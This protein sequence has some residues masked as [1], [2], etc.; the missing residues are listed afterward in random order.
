MSSL[1]NHWL[2]RLAESEKP[3]YLM[4]PDMI[5]EDLASGRLRARDRLPALRD[6]ADALRLNYTTVARGYAEA[7]KRG[8][9]DAKAGSGT[10]VRGR[11][12]ALPLQAGTGAEMSMNMPPEP[13]SMTV[14]LREAAARILGDADPYTLL[15][16]QDFGGTPADRSIAT[17]W[18]RQQLPDCRP[19]TVL[20]CPGIHSA[21]VALV[22]QLARP[23][24]TICLDTLAYPGIKAIAAQLGV[25]L[26][27]LPS[28]EEGPLGPAF[29]ALCRT[30][31]PSAFYINPTLQNPSTRTMPQGRREILADIALRYNVPIIED[32]AYGMLPREAPDP[33]A[34]LAPEL[35]YYVTGMSK[36]FGAGL[37]IAFL[38]APT[39]RQAQR[40]AGTLRATTVM[41]SP[42]NTLLTTSWIQDGT[43]SDMIA[44]IRAES[45]ARQAVARDVLTAGAGHAYDADPEGFHL[46]LPI[47]AAS[48]WRPSELALHLRSRGIGVVSS[49]AFST[50][51][52]P[53]DAVRI[54]LGGPNDLE[55][56]EECLQIV[57]DT[58]D[59]PHHLHT[60]ML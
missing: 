9:I 29:E 48:G 1:A 43:A 12:P 49:A 17:A 57:V 24:Q 19:D 14:R 38:S 60:A 41:A 56:M 18:L 31:L 33:M 20:I 3:A 21:L 26:Q 37:R 5:E 36:T 10:F 47:P 30:Q 45:V 15:R 39:P 6:L 34:R 55:E 22:S 54:C 4:I 16:Y 28:D 23:G 7:R 46:W 59:D 25:Q 13:A 11:A 42:F 27:A 2:K 40:L 53:P 8:L 51:G 52:N 44:A 50:D 58:L 32:D 35:T